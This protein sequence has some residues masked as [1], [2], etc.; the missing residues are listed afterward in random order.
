MICAFFLS[1]L[2][3]DIPKHLAGIERRRG[4]QEGNRSW[5]AKTWNWQPELVGTADRLNHK[6]PTLLPKKHKHSWLCSRIVL[7]IMSYKPVCQSRKAGQFRR[8]RVSGR[9]RKK[10]GG[11]WGLSIST[12]WAPT[13]YAAT[14]PK[15]HNPSRRHQITVKI[16]A[17]LAETL[18]Q[19][20]NSL[21][22]FSCIF[23]SIE[24]SWVRQ[25]RW[26]N[27]ASVNVRCKSLS[28]A[29]I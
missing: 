7:P 9:E 21:K 3:F 11:G 12:P 14:C 20:V 24:L 29:N 16:L 5:I 18:Y 6:Y 17:T 28:H 1:S 23:V 27:W 15:A 22:L 25:Y 8:T 10:E 2:Y 19:W 4:T 26:S 13:K